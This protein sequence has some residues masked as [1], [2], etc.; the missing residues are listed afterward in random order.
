MTFKLWTKRTSF[1]KLFLYDEVTESA[2]A[3]GA[4]TKLNVEWVRTIP[5]LSKG[6]CHLIAITQEENY[7]DSI[8]WRSNFC[9]GIW[10]KLSKTIVILTN[11]KVV[12]EG[13]KSIGVPRTNIKFYPYTEATFSLEPKSLDMLPKELQAL[14]LYGEGLSF[15][16]IQE[17]LQLQ[18][19]IDAQRLLRKACQ[20]AVTSNI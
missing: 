4:M 2:P 10:R 7:A 14:K 8:F 18:Y 17:K 11:S 12:K 13:Y 1:K 20:N 19:P 9:Y 3:R 15:R 6:R 5:Q 16:D